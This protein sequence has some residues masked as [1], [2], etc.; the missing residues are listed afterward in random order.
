MVAGALNFPLQENGL[1]LDFSAKIISMHHAGDPEDV[2]VGGEM[3]SGGSLTLAILHAISR[4]LL[5][6]MRATHELLIACVCGNMAHA[7]RSSC[8]ECVCT[9]GRMQK[10][11]T[12]WPHYIARV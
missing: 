3:I 4:A 8:I 6:C 11:R 9:F 12:P 7:L 1:S 2:R 5:V 10:R